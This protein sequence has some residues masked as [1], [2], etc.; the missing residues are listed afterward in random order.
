MVRFH[1]RIPGIYGH[2]RACFSQDFKQ[3]LDLQ[4]FQKDSEAA[5]EVAAQGISSA[6]MKRFRG[7][8]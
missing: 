4:Q 8:L 1:G 6:T 2:Y 3:V 5:R 7:K